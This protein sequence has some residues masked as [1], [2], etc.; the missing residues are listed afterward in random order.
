[1]TNPGCCLLANRSHNI[2]SAAW[3]LKHTVM[4]KQGTG[5]HLD[6]WKA[7]TAAFRR[8]TVVCSSDLL[9]S[10][11]TATCPAATGASGMHT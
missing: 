7:A 2:V 5:Q 4:S 3:T 6:A 9:R 11:S 1:M 10:S 8:S